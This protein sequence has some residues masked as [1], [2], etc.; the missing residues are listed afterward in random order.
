MTTVI[1]VVLAVMALAT[2]SA[3]VVEPGYYGREHVY[4]VPDHDYHYR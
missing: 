3:C 1:K 2:I 4:V